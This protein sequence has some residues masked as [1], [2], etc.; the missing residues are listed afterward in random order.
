M[1]KIIEEVYRRM[2]RIGAAIQ[3]MGGNSIHSG[4][5]SLRDLSD[6]D[7]FY[8]TASGS[9][10]GS[11][12]AKDIVALRFSRR[13]KEDER[14]STETPTH[15]R[16][17]QLQGV[18]AVVHAHCF[19]STL[20]SF[21]S[22]EEQNFLQYV[23]KD[24][25]GREA[26]LFHPVD[27]YGRWCVGDVPV[28]SYLQPV[29]SAEMEQRIPHY[30]TDHSAT[31][32]R[33]HGPFVGADSP[34][35]A[36]HLLTVLETSAEIAVLL[37]RR[38]IDVTGIQNS[39]QSSSEEKMIS[40]TSYGFDYIDFSSS[41]VKEKQVIQEFRQSLSYNYINH[42]GSFA[43]GSMSQKVTNDEMVF[44]PLSALPEGFSLPLQIKSLTPK[45]DDSLDMRLHK[46]IYQHTDQKACMITVSP[47]AVAEAMAV[48]AE[49]YGVKTLIGDAS[50]ISYTEKEH[51]VIT[52]I[53]AE[54]KYCNPRL[55][56]V[57]MTQLNNTASEIPILNMLRWHK[58][59]CVVANY[60]VISTSQTTLE[61]AVHSAALAERAAGFRQEVYF[62]QHIGGK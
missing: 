61:Q 37:R 45:P 36:F 50:S 43:T 9:Q 46:L 54:A 52:A 2:Y 32:V 7:I 21:D 12:T 41:E 16:V 11:L 51:P 57:D 24:G 26:F 3:I 6:P 19:Y 62:N 27:L 29:G 14:A 38:G 8:I 39:I 59:C 23:G 58:G 1:S 13:T 60:G 47:R 31:I 25:E 35:K 56:L 15:R 28:G 42:L 33:S 55:G 34:E 40:L 4:N 22:R 49:K 17:L 30:L 20:I 18:R 53:D 48:L 44:C 10:C 5:I